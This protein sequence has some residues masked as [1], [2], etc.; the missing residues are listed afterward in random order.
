MANGMCL[1]PLLLTD[2]YVHWLKL[3]Q[4]YRQAHHGRAV[5][6]KELQ[7][8]MRFIGYHTNLGLTTVKLLKSQ[9]QVKFNVFKLV[10]GF[11]FLVKLQY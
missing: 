11:S 3:Q 1:H 7:F 5:K 6:W 10:A 4:P 8:L 2:V 9:K